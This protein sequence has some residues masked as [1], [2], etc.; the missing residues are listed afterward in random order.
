MSW[1]S[2]KQQLIEPPPHPIIPRVHQATGTT[3][4]VAFAN[5]VYQVGAKI[6]SVIKKDIDS[7]RMVLVSDTLLIAKSIH[8]LCGGPTRADGVICLAVAK[9]LCPE[10]YGQS[11]PSDLEKILDLLPAVSGSSIHYPISCQ[12]LKQ[13][14]QLHNENNLRF[15]IPVFGRYTVELGKAGSNREDVVLPYAKM[16]IAEALAGSSETS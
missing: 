10:T 4:S 14:D 13:Y 15:L 5:A 1:F 7:V 11:K 2:K 6:S 3:L 8:S 9:T 16:L 12:I